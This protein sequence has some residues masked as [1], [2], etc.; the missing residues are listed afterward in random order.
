MTLSI[1]EAKQ[2]IEAKRIIINLDGIEDLPE[3]DLETF[4]KKSE[5]PAWVL[6][7]IKDMDFIKFY[8]EENKKDE[9]EVVSVGIIINKNQYNIERATKDSSTYKL[10]ELYL[11]NFNPLIG[12]YITNTSDKDLTEEELLQSFI[13]ART[14]FNHIYYFEAE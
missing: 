3:K 12:Y 10:N 1:F 7:F 11:S 5:D 9:N 2:E 13:D 14:S 8:A 6:K 4:N